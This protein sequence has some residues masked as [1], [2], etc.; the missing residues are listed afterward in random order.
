MHLVG[1]CEKENAG[2]GCFGLIPQSLPYIPSRT[3]LVQ[4][5]IPLILSCWEGTEIEDYRA[6]TLGFLQASG[7]ALWETGSGTQ[8]GLQQ[9]PSHVLHLDPVVLRMG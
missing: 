2:H 4:D 6:L 9:S 8:E 1:H 7:W 5:S 3:S